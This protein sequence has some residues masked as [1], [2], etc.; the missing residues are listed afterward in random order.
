MAAA[1]AV[2]WHGQSTPA[3]TAVKLYASELVNRFSPEG[4]ITGS[5]K[6]GFVN[7]ASSGWLPGSHTLKNDLSDLEAEISTFAPNGDDGHA[8]VT[9]LSIADSFDASS[10]ATNYAVL[11]ITSPPTLAEEQNAA[12][13][14]CE[15]IYSGLAHPSWD[16]S[17]WTARCQYYQ[18]F[19]EDNNLER[20]VY[21]TQ[22]GTN[23]LIN[24]AY[25]LNDA[26]WKVA[27]VAVNLRNGLSFLQGVY[28]CGSTSSVADTG[29]NFCKETDSD[30]SARTLAFDQM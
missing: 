18:S 22:L 11:V 20:P 7:Y 10:G 9:G 26:G 29:L 6:F 5:L 8:A 21:Q 23:L 14:F 30:L 15:L 17:M 13:R 2:T 24:E 19:P 3:T 16:S 1:A 25:H 28:N 12:A 27:V 4:Y